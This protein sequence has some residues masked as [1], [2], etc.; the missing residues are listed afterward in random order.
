MTLT[1]ETRPLGVAVGLQESNSATSTIA[2]ENA[3]PKSFP[4]PYAQAAK[5]YFERGW[6]NPIPVGNRPGQKKPV[7]EGFTGRAGSKVP[8]DQMIE[9]S[10]TR[11][12]R[13]I[14]IRLPAFLMAF[15]VDGQEGADA[16]AA[17]ALEL[18]VALP[19]TY[20]S[21]SRGPDSLKRHHFYRIPWTL[22]L[23]RVEGVIRKRYGGLLDVL[24]KGHRYAVVGPSV[25]PEG[26]VY[27]WYGPDGQPSKL[28]NVKDLPELPAEWVAFLEAMRP[29][30]PSAASAAAHDDLVDEVGFSD[31]LMTREQVE[32]A[33]ARA[34]E[35]FGREYVEG[36]RNNAIRD[37]AFLAWHYSCV[38]DVEDVWAVVDRLGR[39]RFGYPSP[40]SE[41]SGSMNR[42]WLD[43][44][45]Q[46]Q[47]VAEIVEETAGSSAIGEERNPHLY[48]SVSWFQWEEAHTTPEKRAERAEKDLA[49]SSWAPRD[50]SAVL[51]GTFV[52]P[53]PDLGFR[54]DGALMLYSGKE[55]SIASEPEC[56]KT[57]WVLLQVRAVLESGGNVLY[58]D[59]EDDEGTIVGR[60]HHTLGV[61]VEHLGPERFRYVRPEAE[62]ARKQYETLLS[63]GPALVVL[64]GVT[65]GMN[66]LGLEIN[67]NDNAT[68]WRR[69]FVRPAMNIGAATLSTDHVVKDRDSRG[70]FAIGGQHKLAGLNGAMFKLEQVHPFGKGLKGKSRV[71]CAKDRNGGLRAKGVPTK[72]TGMTYMGDLVGDATTEAAQWHFYPPQSDQGDPLDDGLMP[73]EDLR[74]AVVKVKRFLEKHSGSTTREVRAAAGVSASKTGDALA[75][76][77]ISGLASEDVGANRAKLWALSGSDAFPD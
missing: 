20:T 37:F 26:G 47:W 70:R 31:H 52:M 23:D 17:I 27:A 18:G 67:S 49:G 10:A 51:D 30:D 13:N 50:I 53:E 45:D 61:S 22:N 56:G 60:L 74:D 75:W 73:P 3:D 76:L 16:L 33:W 72:S 12:D 7:P 42:A 2:S 44:R 62:P 8:W 21:T 77:K 11:A 29:A 40:D 1:S 57:W 43:G 68:V 55:H 35:K 41:D 19:P 66:L 34:V 14:G 38:Y 4:H 5:P 64:D 69:T 59:F 58:V 65:E 46:G 25:H 24:H 54:S 39:E 48:E 63:F 71:L 9:W 32:A 36:N 15:D 6:E 28:P